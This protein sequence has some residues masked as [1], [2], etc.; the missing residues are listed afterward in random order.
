MESFEK[1]RDLQKFQTRLEVAHKFQ[2]HGK[3]ES[4]N[5][6][7]FS[8]KKDFKLQKSVWSGVGLALPGVGGE[9]NVRRVNWSLT[10]A[11]VVGEG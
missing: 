5:I 3:I 11:V 2:V 8:N 10:R 4:L 7:Q 6:Y 1:F 9:R